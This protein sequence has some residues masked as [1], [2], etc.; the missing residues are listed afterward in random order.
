MTN[1]SNRAEL[2]RHVR[3]AVIV[4]VKERMA[5]TGETSPWGMSGAIE[6][7]FPGIPNDVVWD[8]IITIDGEAAESWWDSLAKT[9]DGEIVR[10]A[11]ARPQP[12]KAE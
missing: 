8:A 3:A 11:L 5:E 4:F 12:A 2:E 9:I 1:L 6:A 10:N 7:A